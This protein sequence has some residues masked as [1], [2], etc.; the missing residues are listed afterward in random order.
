VFLVALSG[1]AL[2]EDVARA[3]TAGFNRHLAKPAW[4]LSSGC[5][6]PRPL[7]TY[8][9]RRKKCTGASAWPRSLWLPCLEAGTNRNGSA[10][11]VR[12]F[13][14]CE[15][16]GRCFMRL[17]HG[18]GAVTTRTLGSLSVCADLLAASSRSIPQSLRRAG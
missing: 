9:S 7:R 3:Q 16:G 5:W 8:F 4:R 10:S 13:H 11:I 15:L 14:E 1:Y 12:S 17:C 2:P 18:R 6:Q